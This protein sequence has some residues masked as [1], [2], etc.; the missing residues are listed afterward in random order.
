MT[1]LVVSAADTQPWSRERAA[2][3]IVCQQAQMMARA[4]IAIHGL[5]NADT[6]LPRPI[7]QT[8]VSIDNGL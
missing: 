5:K 1:E 8:P 7:G 4:A 2:F 3:S 6:R